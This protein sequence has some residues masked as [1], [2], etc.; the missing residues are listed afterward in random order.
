MKNEYRIT[1]IDH[2]KVNNIP[3]DQIANA[4][5]SVY[6]K[7]FDEVVRYIGARP[8]RYRCGWGGMRGNTEYIITKCK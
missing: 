2:N 3:F 6:V 7:G 8:I 4:S 1:V 5:H